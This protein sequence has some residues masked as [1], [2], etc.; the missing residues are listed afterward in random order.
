MYRN[1]F[2]AGVDDEDVCRELIGRGFMQQH[3]T[4]EWLPYLNCSVTEA[5]KAAMFAESPKP[6]KLSRSQQRYRRYLK[7]D[8]GVSFWEW[9]KDWEP[10][11]RGTI[12]LLI[13][14]LLFPSILS[15]QSCSHQLTRTPN[16][17]VLVYR[18][19]LLQRQGT[20]YTSVN[21]TGTFF[22]IITPIAFGDQD[23]MSAVITR[24]VP[25]T[26]TVPGPPPQ[27]V[28]Y[29]SYALWREDWTCAGSQGTPPAG[30]FP[31]VASDGAGG[32][33]IAGSLA[34]GVG[35]SFDA[36]ITWGGITYRLPTGDGTGKV[37]ADAGLAPCG[38]VD[39]RVLPPN[40]VCH[41]F[42]WQ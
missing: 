28:T 26:F 27:M 3:R 23:L 41:Q 24:A 42:V 35:T 15:A 16:G 40:P 19:G 9:L 4:T 2:C 11:L 31:G 25:L 34:T 36:A 8:V 13:I 29:F 17:P 1:H 37:L 20:D 32:L 6:P 5:G 12:V 18:N 21:A 7:A 30:P 10:R 14:S 39:L 38:N 22:P 33:A